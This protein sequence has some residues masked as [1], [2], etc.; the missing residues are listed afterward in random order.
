MINITAFGRHCARL[1]LREAG[2]DFGLQPQGRQV[3]TRRGMLL[4]Q[5]VQHCLETFF[6]YALRCLQEAGYDLGPLREGREAL[7][8]PVCYCCCLLSIA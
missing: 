1:C 2:Y 6:F 3:L 8:G 5:P 4:L 7:A